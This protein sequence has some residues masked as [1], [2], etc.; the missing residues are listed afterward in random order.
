MT[1]T[2]WNNTSDEE[3]SKSLETANKFADNLG[4]NEEQRS[5]LTGFLNA[6]LASMADEDPEAP[7]ICNCGVE[8]PSKDVDAW[9]RCP[10][11]RGYK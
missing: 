6:E 11:E 4:F 9:G 3:K 2:N 8:W 7:I 5:A 10:S 1:K